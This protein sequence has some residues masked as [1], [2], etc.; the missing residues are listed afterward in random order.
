MTKNLAEVN[1]STL[2][3]VGPALVKKLAKLGIASVQDILF[4][5]PFRYEDRTRVTPVRA[6]RPGESCV[7]E[8]KI[9]ACEVAFGR[10]RSLL[11]RLQDATG[12]ISLRFYHFSKAQQNNL[13]KIGAVRCFGEVRVGASGYE[14]YHPE[15][16]ALSKAQQM[17]D[18]LTPIYPA[19]EGITQSRFRHLVTQALD[20]LDANPM[21][22][23][24]ATFASVL[25][26]QIT[27][28]TDMDINQ[29]VRY[30][31]L[32]PPDADTDAL[33]SGTHPAQT[34]LAFEEL[35]AHQTSLRII[36]NELQKL[37]A[38][39][40]KAPGALYDELH[41]SLGFELT[42][43]QVKVSGEVAC[44]M[45]TSQPSLRLIQG[46]VGSGK[47]VIAALAAIHAHENNLQ[48]ALMAPTELLAGQHFI[49]LSIW[50]NPLGI[51]TALLSARVTGKKRQQALA[52]V[53][54]G[55][56]TVI[57]GTHALI[58]RQVE[59]KHLGLIIV[60]EQHRFGV[61]QRLALRG[62]NSTPN[63]SP[64]QLVMTAT[65]IPRTLSMSIYADMDCSTIDEL[66][67]GRKPV[68]TSVLADSR[69]EQ[70]ID[71][72]AS[73]CSEGIQAYWVCTLIDES[74]ALQCQAAEVTAAELKTRLPGLRIGLIHGRMNSIEKTA[75][76]NEF[77][78]AQL[79][80]LVA[81]TVIEVGVDV[82]AASLMV[83]E[84]SERLGLAQLHQLRGR[85]GRGS[86]TSHCVLLYKKPLGAVSRQRLEVM[87]NSNDG[88][89]IA[90]RDLE[91]RGP[92][93][94]SGTRQSGSAQFRIADLLRDKAMLPE[95]KQ[96][97]IT[98]LAENHAA[99][100]LLVKRWLREP[101]LMGQL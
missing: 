3:G 34:R 91:I 56:A 70:V 77:K 19:T 13:A 27:Q 88:F 51:N 8:G 72:V 41:T 47:T 97:A 63:E 10:R 7:L 86:A 52:S 83:I 14:I 101:E 57:I 20:S 37:N 43:A 85:V 67:P 62:K 28:M 18:A 90:E 81:T 61:H 94:M 23:G 87:R 21:S 93:E 32:P 76:M 74:E 59:F 66:P 9:I 31:H 84:N 2:K 54:T 95:V 71:R 96:T 42:R 11:A 65:P 17:D 79:D 89:Y 39:Q 15:Y 48:T 78:Q 40:L 35:V 22:E 64:H 68:T 58:Q 25:P 30:L 75:R 16:I 80:L 33:M 36:R 46:D 1:V 5:L 12:I 53:A 29:A 4:H 82:P 100:D 98:L 49:T 26:D 60:D 50:L 92:G 45:M 55:D 69:R 73:A 24:I 6:A 44:D 38:P 99:A